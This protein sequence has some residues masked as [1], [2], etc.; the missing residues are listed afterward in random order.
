MSKVA[1]RILKI[2][3][4]ILF[5]IFAVVGGILLVLYRY[6]RYPGSVLHKGPDTGAEDYFILLFWMIGLALI[7][8]LIIFF[9][10]PIAKKKKER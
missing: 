8:L 6:F 4:A 3:K 7:L 5:T 1:K 9:V 10:S 2:T